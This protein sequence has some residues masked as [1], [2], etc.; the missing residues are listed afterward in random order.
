MRRLLLLL[1]LISLACQGSDVLDSEACEDQCGAQ[2]REELLA[3]IA[4]RHDAFAEHLR[5]ATDDSGALTGDYEDVL[6]GVGTILDCAPATERSFVVLSNLGLMPKTVFS[7]CADD[8][9]RASEFFMAAPA[10][11]GS[12]DMDPKRLHIAAWDDDAGRYRHYLSHPDDDGKLR[13][14][15][16]P[17]SCMGCHGGPEGLTTWQPLMNELTSPW[18]QWNAEPGFDSQLFDED[19]DP[20][21]ASGEIYGQ[22]LAADR[23]GS[24][25]E[26]EPLIRAGIDRVTNARIEQRRRAASIDESL[27]LL[28][29]LFC[30]ETANFASE[31][32]RSGDL[33]MATVVDDSLRSLLA[34]QYPDRWAFAGESR[35]RLPLPDPDEET[36]MLVPIRG[37]SSLQAE[38]GLLSR[39]VLSADD[40]LRVRALDYSRPV[41]SEFRCAL[42]REGAARARAG[43]ADLLAQLPPEATNT[44]LA[45]IL[46]QEIMTLETDGSR[47]P[48]TSPAGTIVAIA[49]AS[50]VTPAT[51]ASSI[52]TA[53]DL[54]DSIEAR[55]ETITRSELR[56]ARD[57]RGCRAQERYPSAPITPGLVCR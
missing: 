56:A 11:T 34:A 1:A 35:F 24:A 38:R 16:E 18:A 39:R 30:D 17:R 37:E 7:R 10:T 31:V 50:T 36:V 23:L 45:P 54:G 20:E 9:V 26:F 2:S 42:Y 44:E 47:T 33:R 25:S 15:V 41:L 52:T 53:A 21:I 48:I 49:D 27:A 6:D 28:R 22:M 12:A 29:P 5:A 14:G 43:A 55:F 51:I 57:E 3:A 32:H 4:D 19:L 8:P 40:V 13:I 46:L